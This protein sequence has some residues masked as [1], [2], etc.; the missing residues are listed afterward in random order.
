MISA[1]ASGQGKTVLTLGLLAAMRAAGQRV[2]GAKS[3]PDFIDPG[4]HAAATGQPAVTLD[5][6]AAEPGQ[7]AARARQLAPTETQTLLVEGAMGL[8]DGAA[9]GTATGTGATAALARALDLPVLL[10]LDGARMGQSAGALAQGLAARLGEGRLAGVILNRVAS[11]RHEAMLRD[12]MGALPVLGVVPSGALPALPAR[13]LGLVQAIEHP[14][15]RGFLTDAA[16]AVAAACDLAA[17]AAL[18]RE[19]PQAGT[20]R[21]LAPLGQRI[22]VAQD[23]AFGFAYAHLLAD[24]RAQGAELLPFSPLADQAPDASADAI[25]LPGGYP[26]LY[27]S[28]VARAQGFH[29]GMARAASRNVHIYGECGGYMVLGK[30][31]LDENG[32][33]HR[34]LGLL[35]LE[36]SFA[37]RRRH[38]GYRRLIGAAPFEGRYAAHEFHYCTTLHATGAPLFQAEDAQGT[39]LA[40]M[41]LRQGTVMGSFAHLIEAI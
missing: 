31:L 36:T 11:P 19:L 38:L 13:H 9:N 18:A 25:F 29:A 20:P 16:T 41:G 22:A 7:L 26:E 28:I 34:M 21:R 37:E 1:P 30:Q 4:F 40:P 27:A 17:I 12:G 32:T 15:L 33:A 5:A 6:F 24:W 8:F 23:A 35:D 39:R 10:V 14:D 2:A 3:G